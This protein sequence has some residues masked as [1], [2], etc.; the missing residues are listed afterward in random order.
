MEVNPESA[1]PER[2]E[3]VMQFGA[4][5]LSLGLQSL[6]AFLLGK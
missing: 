5:R 1:F 6:D 4:S 3:T 2:L